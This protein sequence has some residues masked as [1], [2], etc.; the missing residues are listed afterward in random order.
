MDVRDKL[1]TSIGLAGLVTTFA[2]ATKCAAERPEMYQISQF[3][4]N[5]SSPFLYAILGA[6]V[7]ASA[8]ALCKY[9]SR[10]LMGLMHG[11]YKDREQRRD[12]RE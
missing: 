5:Q 9:G 2:V 12:R 4:D 1:A 11:E 7:L 10:Y 8:F 6:A 3:S